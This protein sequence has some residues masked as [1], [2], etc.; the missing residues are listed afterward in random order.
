MNAHRW[1]RSRPVWRA[2]C[3]PSSRHEESRASSKPIA[4]RSA[5]STARAYRA[6]VPPESFAVADVK[7]RVREDISSWM[8]LK[9][10]DRRAF[11]PIG[12]LT[13]STLADACSFPMSREP[14]ASMMREL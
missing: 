12:A 3:K 4:S 14:A 10:R 1:G 13:H 8:W 5:N 7:A 2:F 6:C 9:V 11:D